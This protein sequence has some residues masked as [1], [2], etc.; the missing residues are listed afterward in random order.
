MTEIP[1]LSEEQ[2]SRAI[3]ARLRQRLLRGEF[4]SG[5]DVAALRRFVGYR[6]V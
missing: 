3:P 6:S 1:E 4:K 5:T 2:C